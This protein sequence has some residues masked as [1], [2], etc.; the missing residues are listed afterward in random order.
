MTEAQTS[1]QSI[2]VSIMGKEYRVACPAGEQDALLRA[3]NLLDTRMRDIRD[4]GV[5]GNERIAVMAALNLSH[6]YLDIADSSRNENSDQSQV[7]DL[8]DKLDHELSAYRAS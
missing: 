3:A 6:E 1:T 7:N 4:A 5:S 2:T 8:I